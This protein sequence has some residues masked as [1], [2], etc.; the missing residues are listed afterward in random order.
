[1]NPGQLWFKRNAVRKSYYVSAAAAAVAVAWMI[2]TACTNS[3]WAAGT[4][5]ALGA[6]WLV[7]A[8]YWLY[9]ARQLRRRE[10]FVHTSPEPADEVLALLEQ[11]RKIAAIKRYREL[12]P[13]MGLR[14]AKDVIDDIYP[15]G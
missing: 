1:V 15:A 14:D 13:G 12:N 7:L 4:G 11:G 10:Q 8:G 3:S 5:I 6:V 9:A 2:Y